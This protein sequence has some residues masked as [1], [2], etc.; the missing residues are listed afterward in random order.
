[1]AIK[2]RK[3][4]NEEMFYPVMMNGH[5]EMFL[6]PNTMKVDEG[7]LDESMGSLTSNQIAKKFGKYLGAKKTSRVLLNRFVAAVA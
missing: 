6:L 5:T 2:I 7:D 1:M 4:F 3:G